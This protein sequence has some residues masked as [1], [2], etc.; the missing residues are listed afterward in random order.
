MDNK[1]NLGDFL[2]AVGT[3]MQVFDVDDDEKINQTMIAATDIMKLKM[4][5]HKVVKHMAAAEFTFAKLKVEG[6]VTESGIEKLD[7]FIS[8]TI[9][10]IIDKFEM[11]TTKEE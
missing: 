6:N 10:T 8:Q 3:L 1:I 2:H 4:H 9:K 7:I 5:L 11:L